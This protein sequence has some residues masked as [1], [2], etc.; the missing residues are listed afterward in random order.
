MAIIF[1][2]PEVDPRPRGKLRLFSRRM[3]APAAPAPSKP[4]TI[5][6]ISVLVSKHGAT[7]DLAEEFVVFLGRIRD[8]RRPYELSHRE[9]T[10][11]HGL[12]AVSIPS[13]NRRHRLRQ[14]GQPVDE[15]TLKL[16]NRVLLEPGQTFTHGM[17]RDR[18][19]VVVSCS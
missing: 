9:A 19:S 17:T 15:S 4:S 3:P 8:A 11:F 2:D 1:R 7:E 13:E 18:C 5:D 16:I 12:L 6:L 10:L 14:S